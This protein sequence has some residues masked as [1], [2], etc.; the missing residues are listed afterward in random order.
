MQPYMY[1][2][3]VYAAAY[4]AA[5]QAAL[6]AALQQQP[7]SSQIPG[8]GQAGPPAPYVM[9]GMVREG[10]AAWGQRC[11]H[12]AR[13]PGAAVSSAWV[14]GVRDMC[15]GHVLA[16]ALLN[17]C[18]FTLPPMTSLQGYM[19]A[20][21]MGAMGMQGA[22]P[23]Q[24]QF[25]YNAA[26]HHPMFAHI[27]AGPHG[28]EIRID[29]VR[30]DALGPLAMAVAHLRQRRGGNQAIGAHQHGMHMHARQRRP[31]GITLRISVR[32]ILQ[33][34]VFA[35]VLYQVRGNIA[36]SRSTV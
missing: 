32:T 8:L 16:A 24:L 26:M 33:V 30:Q 12:A 21:H 34:L 10:C 3:P 23:L 31:R 5:Y 28:P 6:A 25:A 20:A 29:G 36:V 17:P 7:G 11:G 27:Q 1:V 9:T 4:Q 19:P 18:C 2:N 35:M 14:S 13:F 15:L 22:A